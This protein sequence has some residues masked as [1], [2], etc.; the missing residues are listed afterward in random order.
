VAAEK[1]GSVVVAAHHVSIP[2]KDCQS[3]AIEN[4]GATDPESQ[5]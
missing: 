3:P 1:V 2:T 4:R 5:T